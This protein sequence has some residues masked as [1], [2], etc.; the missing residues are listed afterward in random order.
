VQE[1][2]T[3]TSMSYESM[4][5][6][7]VQAVQA[8][9]KELYAAGFTRSRA[10]GAI[11]R[12]LQQQPT[13]TGSS[14][15]TR[16]PP[17][18][19]SPPSEADLVAVMRRHQMT[20]GS[21]KHL[22]VVSQ[23]IERRAQQHSHQNNATRN[24]SGRSKS[25]AT[26]SSIPT[27][28]S[29]VLRAMDDL[30]RIVREAPRSILALH[31][32]A[33][34]AANVSRAPPKVAIAGRAS[35]ND[36]LSQHRVLSSPTNSAP[37][38]GARKQPAT[39]S[40][41]AAPRRTSSALESIDELRA[42]ASA[43][44]QEKKPTRNPAP[45]S[46]SSVASAATATRNN[47]APDGSSSRRKSVRGAAS[48]RSSA[49]L[50]TATPTRARSDSDVEA[51]RTVASKVLSSHPRAAAES[52][53]ASAVANGA[54]GGGSTT[55]ASASSSRKRSR[56]SS[57]GGDGAGDSSSAGAKAPLLPSPAPTVRSS[58]AGANGVGGSNNKRTR[59]RR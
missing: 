23:W 17:P 41:A 42:L 4:R 32:P 3:T 12:L 31:S 8:S 1:D 30:V 27:Q 37:D 45:P 7:L 14:S 52:S 16:G 19:A 39:R 49:A 56:S 21:A 18:A 10:T 54:T 44:E 36:P 55:I 57:G 13:L 24:T 47:N 20:D 48:D 6:E 22:L 46:A 5:R 28:E 38:S 43:E 25:K 58:A 15:F 51:E 34:E 11:V 9:L 59:N 50:A 33:N 29:A 2:S 26:T 53:S 40:N 35:H